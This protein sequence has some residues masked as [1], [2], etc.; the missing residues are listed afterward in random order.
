VDHDGDPATPRQA[1]GVLNVPFGTSLSVELFSSTS[2]FHQDLASAI[3]DDLALCGV[4]VIHQALPNETLYAPGPEGPL[5]GRQFDLALISWLPLPQEDCTLYDSGQIPSAANYWIGTNIAGLSDQLYDDACRTAT[6]ALPVDR[7]EAIHQAERAFLDALPA[8]PLFS[9]PRVM[10]LP[11]TGCDNG[12][13]TTE[14]EFFR[15][16]EAY[17]LGSDCP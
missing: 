1:Q 11:E 16:L 9:I 13:I 4:E 17:H 10:V 15:Q 14:G 12:E 7:D 6:L 8:V 3:R 5:F 2:A